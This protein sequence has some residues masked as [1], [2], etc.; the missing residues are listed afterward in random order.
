[1]IAI[2]DYNSSNIRSVVNALTKIGCEF[3]VTSDPAIILG[4]EKVIFPGVGSASQA[5]KALT[6]YQLTDVI[7]K[8]TA[9][10]LG[11]CLGMQLL[12]DRSEEEDTKCLA[13]IP[14]T[15]R[16]LPKNEVIV[17][18]IGWSEVEIKDN[19][20]LF[21]NIKNKSH[22]YFVH[23]YYCEASQEDTIGTTEYGLPFTSA[24]RYKNF[25][26]MQFHPEKSGADGEQLLRNFIEK[27]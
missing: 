20:P 10:C 14:G 18:N 21:K 19:E 25:Y 13:I 2:I 6:E 8:I 17:P 12:F 24:V 23:S 3:I 15:V 7:P 9:P 22:F 4:A 1:M 11:I 16:L 5:M 27:I 26:G